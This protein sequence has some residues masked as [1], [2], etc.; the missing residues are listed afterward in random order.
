MYKIEDF[1]E[2]FCQTI[3]SHVTGVDFVEANEVFYIDGVPFNNFKKKVV[4]KN[5]ESTTLGV[6]LYRRG[7]GY[8]KRTITNVEG[9]NKVNSKYNNAYAFFS[10]LNAQNIHREI[11]FFHGNR[12]FFTLRIEIEFTG[13][14]PLF[15]KVP[16]KLGKLRLWANT[17]TYLTLKK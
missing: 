10:H 17:Y 4:G 7:F 6:E 3:E 12:M 8:C 14:E 1:S 15:I 9:A 13:D 2:D 11:T 5:G 16:I